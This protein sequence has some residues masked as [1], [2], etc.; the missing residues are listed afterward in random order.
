MKAIALLIS[1]LACTFYL[2]CSGRMPDPVLCYQ[3]GDD[4]LSCEELKIQM[5]EIRREIAIKPAKIKERNA[6]NAGLGALGA[7]LIYP[8]FEA[9]ILEAEEIE[10]QALNTRYNRLFMIAAEKRCPLENRKMV[11]G[12]KRPPTAKE[13]LDDELPSETVR[14]LYE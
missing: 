1:L 14:L 8:W 13:I 11:V 9:D 4:G 10:I 12:T 5:A 7:V 2:G 6:R 3:P